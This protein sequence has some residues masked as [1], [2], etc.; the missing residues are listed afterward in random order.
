MESE[1]QKM[2]DDCIEKY[3]QTLKVVQKA[4]D[5]EL[6]NTNEWMN[7]KVSSNSEH[8]LFSGCEYNCEFIH[9]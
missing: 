3:V 1:H 6:I 5:S 9:C 7:E 8:W 2:V 4:M